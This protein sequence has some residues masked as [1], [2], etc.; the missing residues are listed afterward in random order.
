MHY[1]HNPNVQDHHT[2][3][4]DDKTIGHLLSRR[5]LFMVLGTAGTA[6]LLAGGFRAVMAETIY[7]PMI[8]S[9][10]DGSAV[11][12]TPTATSMPTPT[13]TSQ[14]TA[15]PGTTPIP[16]CVVSPE[17][18][19]GPY[20]VDERLNRSDIRADPSDN[21]ISSGTRLDLTLRVFSVS[22]EACSLLEGAVVDIWHCDATGLYSDVQAEGSAGRKFLRGYQVSNTNGIVNFTTVY[23]GWYPGRS[24]HIHFKVRAE[25][26]S[27]PAYEFTSQFFFNESDT[28]VVHVMQPYADEGPRDTLNSE[29]GIYLNGGG[30]QLLLNLT[31]TTNGYASAFDIGIVM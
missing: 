30:S 5:E 8:Q 10:A 16:A 1:S 12:A 9:G 21:S 4:D 29:D 25:L 24:V 14:P 18:T 28:D 20:F 6:A 3:H 2:D 26:T 19:E 31:Q 13:A 27:S 11:D 23:P 22:N 15:V 17:L 7:L